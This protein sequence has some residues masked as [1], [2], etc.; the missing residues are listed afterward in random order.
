MEEK[1]ITRKEIRDN[2]LRLSTHL[3]HIDYLFVHYVKYMG[4]EEPFKKFLV[5]LKK[6]HKDAQQKSQGTKVR[7]EKKAG[8][9]KEVEAGAEKEEKREE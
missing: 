4:N 3:Q 1:E 7:E 2:V 9:D 6:E 5:E 8:S